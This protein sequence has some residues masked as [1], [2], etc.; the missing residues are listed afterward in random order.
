M[1]GTTHTGPGHVRDPAVAHPAAQR[2]GPAPTEAGASGGAFRPEGL[3]A[4]LKGLFRGEVERRHVEAARG[5]AAA[6]RRGARRLGGPRRR[7]SAVRYHHGANPA[8]LLRDEVLAI[9]GDE[10]PLQLGDGLTVVLV[11]GVNGSG[12]TTTIGKLA[13]R[14]VARGTVGEP[15]RGATRSGPRPGSSS[16][17]GRGRPARTSSAQER[18]ADPGA[19]A[20]DAVKSAD[21]TRCRRAARGHGREGCTRSSR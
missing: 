9:L 11:V 1:Q 15:R 3:G 10:E 13:K 8:H 21:G 4:R 12:K 17:S 19:V 5:P 7:A 6:R 14:L 16:R 2:T 18:G 20:F